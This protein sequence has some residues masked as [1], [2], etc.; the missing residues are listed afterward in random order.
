MEQCCKYKK[1]NKL[2]K[3][4]YSGEFTSE[5]LKKINYHQSVKGLHNRLKLAMESKQSNELR[6]YYWFYNENDNNDDNNNINNNG[7]HNKKN[8]TAQDGHA[9][10]LILTLEEMSKYDDE[11]VKYSLTLRQLQIKD[12]V[13]L[14]EK[15]EDV[16]DTIEEKYNK[17]N[18]KLQLIIQKLKKKFNNEKE[19]KNEIRIP[20]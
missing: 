13:K 3:D 14:S 2:T 12:T 8:V 5:S 4:T 17:T 18:E 6:A 1:K 15:L 9:T 10:I 7:N 16:A 11:S 20:C 19:E